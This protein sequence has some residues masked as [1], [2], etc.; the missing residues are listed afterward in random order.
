VTEL[1]EGETLRQELDRRALPARKAMDYGVQIAKGLSAA[2][3]KG[4]VHRDLKPEN[5]FVTD[6]GHVKILDFGLAKLSSQGD[7][8][9]EQTLSVR[10]AP[11]A[12]LGT[13]AYMSPEQ[14]RGLQTDARSD[15]F[16]LG[17]ILYEMLSGARRFRGRRRQTR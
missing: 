14:A 11:G 9:L 4:I 1:L 7:A 5:L 3:G 17:A 6:G 2:H 10:T 8:E 12:V 13:A 16:S 15:I